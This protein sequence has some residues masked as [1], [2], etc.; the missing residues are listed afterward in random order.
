MID[1][2]S[3]ICIRK[4]MKIS[5]FSDYCLR[6]LIFLAVTRDRNVSA[7]EISEYYNVSFHHIAKASK[8]LTREGYLIAIKGKGGGL[9]LSRAPEDIA[10]GSVIRKAEDGIGMVECMRKDGKCAIHGAC[11]L[12]TILKKAQD[13]FY[14]TLDEFSLADTTKNQKGIVQ[15]LELDFDN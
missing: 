5:T 11:G 6:I 9:Q 7:R 13:Q 1:E 15:L 10:I 3:E 8:W 2:S 12:Q 4:G 14:K